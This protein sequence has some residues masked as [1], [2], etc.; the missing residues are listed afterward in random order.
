MDSF[1]DSL[2]PGEA[3]I[4]LLAI[5]LLWINL[6]TDAFPAFALGMEKGEENIMDQKPRNTKEQILNKPTLIKVFIQGFGVML[7]SLISFKIGLLMDDV[8]H[9]R[10][11]IFVTIIFGELFRTYSARSETKFILNL[12][13]SLIKQLIIQYLA[14]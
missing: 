6:M 4:P 3:I 1:R 2:N 13:R 11:M 14:L 10:T 9:A 12:I 5:H 8:I 7:A